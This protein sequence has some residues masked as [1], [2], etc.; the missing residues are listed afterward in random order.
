ME[1]REKVLSIGKSRP[2]K[3]MTVKKEEREEKRVLRGR[4]V[5]NCAAHHKQEASQGG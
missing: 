2:P 1:Q 5:T 3:A 4:S